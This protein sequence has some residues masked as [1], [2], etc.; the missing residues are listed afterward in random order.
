MP[1]LINSFKFGAG[2]GGT[3]FVV[4]PDV[5]GVYVYSD[6]NGDTV[7]GAIVLTPSGG[8]APY[9]YLWSRVSGSP[10]ITLAVNGTAVGTFSTTG[11][12]FIS[13][14]REAVW[15]CVI[16]DSLGATITKIVPIEMQVGG[17]VN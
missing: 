9:T 6:F 3:G 2:G 15:Q 5:D 8:T 4:T 16:T 14:L 11:T 12:R 1:G 13:V 10:M 17:G 7:T